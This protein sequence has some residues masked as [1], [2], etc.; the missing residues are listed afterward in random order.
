M[1]KGG[2]QVVYL[3]KNSTFSVPEIKSLTFQAVVFGEERQFVAE[4]GGDV[5]FVT[6]R[7]RVKLVVSAKYFRRTSPK[8]SSKLAN[9]KSVVEIY[10]PF[11]TDS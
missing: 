10:P 6:A 8:L 4:S 1:I 2:C 11:G 3:L 5:S 9:L 7:N